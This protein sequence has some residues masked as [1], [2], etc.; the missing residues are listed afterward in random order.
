M[1]MQLLW[2]MLTLKYLMKSPVWVLCLI[3]RW[4]LWQTWG[5]VPGVA[6]INCYKCVLCAALCPS[7]PQRPYSCRLLQQRTVRHHHYQSAS[8]SVS[9]QRSCTSHHR[10]ATV[11]P[12]HWP[13]MTLVRRPALPTSLPTHPIQVVL[14]SQQVPAPCS[15]VVPGQ[16]VHISVGDILPHSSAFC[17]SLWHRRSTDS[18]A[19]LWAL[20]FRRL[21]SSDWNSLPPD[22]RETSVSAASF[23]SQLNRGVNLGGREGH[24]P[25]IWSGAHVLVW[26]CSVNG[27]DND[28]CYTC[29]VVIIIMFI[30]VAL[31]KTE[32]CTGIL[33]WRIIIQ[34]G[35]LA[36]WE[37]FCSISTFDLIWHFDTIG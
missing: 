34:T 28:T 22:F 1:S 12:H 15:T 31:I 17:H 30:Y 7:T 13:C 4:H 3:A 23:F 9:Y 5:S 20:Q 32:K 24:A 18:L 25:I 6:F 8:T 27:N 11:R 10:Q 36:T 35:H 2:P 19:P 16:H 26:T 14:V 33:K 29:I 21:R 37:L